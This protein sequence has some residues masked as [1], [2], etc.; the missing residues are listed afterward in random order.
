MAQ[1]EQA[2]HEQIKHG[3]MLSFIGASLIGVSAKCRLFYGVQ[4]SPYQLPAPLRAI[5]QVIKDLQE[6]FSTFGTTLLTELLE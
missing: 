4:G 3:V 5:Y 2:Q 1:T 6:I